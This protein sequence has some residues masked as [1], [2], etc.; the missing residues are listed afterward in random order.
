MDLQERDGTPRS[1]DLQARQC[2]NFQLWYFDAT[3]AGHWQW[4]VLCSQ[5]LNQCHLEARRTQ[6]EKPGAKVG[7]KV[8]DSFGNTSANFVSEGI[9][10]S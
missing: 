2:C 7:T 1:P 8:N 5:L 9:T 6:Q 3:L 10:H 4:L